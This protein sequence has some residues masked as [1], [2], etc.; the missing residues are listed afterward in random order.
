M[1]TLHAKHLLSLQ[2]K[3]MGLIG[4]KNIFPVYF[5]TRFGIHTFG[6]LWPIDVLILNDDNVVVKI[7]EGLPPNR[8][9]FWNPKYNQV[10]ELPSG[11]IKEKGIILADTVKI[12]EVR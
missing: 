10:V 4:K 7:V 8:V 2:E 9:L 5:T 12:L 6:V 11:T 1:I 3:S